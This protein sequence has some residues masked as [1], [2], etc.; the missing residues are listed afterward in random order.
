MCLCSTPPR[1]WVG[2]SVGR[3]GC[4]PGQAGTQLGTGIWANHILSIR[5]FLTTNTC[6]SRD[7]RGT[8]GGHTEERHRTYAYKHTPPR[9]EAALGLG[10]HKLLGVIPGQHLHNVERGL[11]EASQPELLFRI[12]RS[13][14]LTRIRTCQ[15]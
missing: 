10:R 8:A 14:H 6:A 12:N 3:G 1:F 9:S 7:G 13:V 15:S 5:Q 11:Q 4:P 2:G